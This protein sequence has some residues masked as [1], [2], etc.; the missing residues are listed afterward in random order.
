MLEIGE[1]GT[2][3]NSNYTFKDG[4]LK[5]VSDKQNIKQAIINRLNTHEDWYELFYNT[6]GGFLHSFHG[7]KRLQDTLDFLKI[8]IINILSQDPR[9]SDFDVELEF[10]DSGEI[11]MGIDLFYDDDSDLSLS[12]VISNSGIIVDNDDESED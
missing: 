4:D 11:D 1:F 12:F 6:Y 8:E 10:N 2:D 3:F 9:F 7:W 5:L